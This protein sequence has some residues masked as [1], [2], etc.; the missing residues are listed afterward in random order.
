MAESLPPLVQPFRGER[1]AQR[2]LSDVIAPPYDVISPADRAALVRRSGHNIVH[3]ILPEGN[4]DRYANAARVLGEWRRQQVLVRDPEPAVYVLQ[5]T[6]RLPDGGVRVRTGMIAAVAVEPYSAGRVKPHEKTHAGPKADRLA[7]V[8]ALK[9]TFESIFLLARDRGSELR[10]GL[11]AVTRSAPT[12]EGDLEGVGVKVWR[13]TGA[14][15][16]LLAA[17]AGR[18]PLYIA[19]GHHRYETTLAFRSEVPAADRT[20]ALIVPLGDSGLAVLP[21][22]RLVAGRAIDAAALR[23]AMSG[24]FQLREHSSPAEAVSQLGE[25]STRC[26]IAFP[27]RWLS[28]VLQDGADVDG[29]LGSVDGVVRRLDVARVDGLVVKTI[30]EMAGA[31]EVG[32]TA[33]ADRAFAAV[34]G[35]EAAAAVLLRPTPVT[36]VLAVADAGGVMPQKS[37]YFVPKV[38]SGI[39]GLV[40][41]Q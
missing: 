6:T 7:L 19:D 35:G 39:V 30:R 31:N 23:R 36:D 26:V 29:A 27:G 34:S 17:I 10:D 2:R 15:A 22:H 13:V 41:D 16:G 21:T 37:T 5:Q 1:Y 9:G 8:R 4:G 40:Y 18:D 28:A 32:Y 3:L 12:A 24:H 11:A 38:P 20:A 25:G 33:D 14:E